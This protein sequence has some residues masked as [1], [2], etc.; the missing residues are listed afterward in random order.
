MVALLPI[1]LFFRLFIF[2]VV[3]IGL[4]FGKYVLLP[5]KPEPATADA[6]IVL[7]GGRV[8]TVAEGVAL[9]GT[10]IAPNL[11]I[12]NGKDPTR[13]TLNRLCGQRKPARILCP[14]LP[15]RR[16][17]AL[18]AA[19]ELAQK[20]GWTRVIF[21]ASSERAAEVSIRLRACK[22]RAT[23]IPAT[24]SGFLV[25]RVRDVITEARPMLR[26]AVDRDCRV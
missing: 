25:S 21:I 9:A 5:P 3:G 23:V 12:P 26:A 6:V 19:V 24:P 18:P 8:D 13:P 10:R 17:Q 16:D 11:V 7:Q 1:R 15:T 20:R 22:L 2:A 4:V 14:Q